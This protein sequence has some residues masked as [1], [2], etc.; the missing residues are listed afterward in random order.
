MQ[1]SD[2]PG[3]A[4]VGPT[5]SGKTLLGLS[6]A[7]RYGGEIVSCDALQVYQGM[8]IGTA[9]ATAAER[10][11]VPHHMLDLRNPD[12]DYSAGDYQRDARAAL[13]NIR[14][15]GSIPFVV[16]GTGFYLR[17]LIDGFFEGPTRSEA[18][19]AR[20]RL[21]IRG[22]KTQL[23]YRVFQRIDP[24]SADRIDRADTARIIRAF[25][26]YLLTGKP[27]SWWRRQPRNAL[28]GFRW[29]K[30]GISLPR[31]L[32]Y[33]KINRRVEEMFANG[34]VE[35]VRR[36]ATRFPS[37]CQAFKAI[38]YCQIANYLNGRITLEQAVETTQQESRR[39]AKRQLTWF[40]SDS[41]I[42]WL[43]GSASSEELQKQ[44]AQVVE[45]FIAAA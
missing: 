15:G 3:I 10:G 21:I 43:D 20:L 33:E 6:L 44:G 42:L 17:A 29:L 23:L 40:R 12:E 31:P 41:T 8:D 14:R 27:M 7:A 11:F 25:E 2:S 32:L 26:I 39:Y 18:I 13:E 16:G 24:E 19:R 45:K 36:L 37:S 1:P 5:A 9:K 30:L 28:T 34:F 22:G 38:G 35:E 4:I